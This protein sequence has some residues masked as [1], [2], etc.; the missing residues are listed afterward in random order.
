MGGS[1]LKRIVLSTFLVHYL[2]AF[3]NFSKETS[4]TIKGRGMG[5]FCFDFR[6]KI[7]SHRLTCTLY[8]VDGNEGG[9]WVTFGV[10]WMFHVPSSL[11]ST[12]QNL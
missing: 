5:F 7:R 8:D 9:L 11:L 10:V 6:V 2:S 1:Y 4:Y 12:I 3:G